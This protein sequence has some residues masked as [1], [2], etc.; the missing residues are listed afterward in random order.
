V[1]IS[2]SLTI[3]LLFIS[4]LA[5]CGSNVL[6]P[7]LGP[8]VGPEFM[9]LRIEIVSPRTIEKNTEVLFQIRLTN[10]N[11]E[12]FLITDPQFDVS[13]NME[14]RYGIGCMIKS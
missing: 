4:S 11:T 5:D 14:A 8:T 2:G 3:A 10:T 12:P 6:G 9:G 7:D 1:R 13:R